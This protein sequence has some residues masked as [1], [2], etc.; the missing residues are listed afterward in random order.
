MVGLEGFWGCFIYAIL[1]P[2]FQNVSCSKDN[3]CDTQNGKIED[4]LSAFQ[5]MKNDSSLILYSI[6]IIIS[7]SA[8]NAC[9]VSITKYAAAS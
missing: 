8:F 6:G 2:I 3:I 4:S 5:D 1:L 7:I 9:G